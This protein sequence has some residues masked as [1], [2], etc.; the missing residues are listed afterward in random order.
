MTGTPI[1]IDVYRASDFV[2]TNGVARGEPLSFAD[3][4]MLDD[5]YQ[6]APGGR[7]EQLDLAPQTGQTVLSRRD[8]PYSLVHLDCCITLMTPQGATH[9]A[10]ILVEVADDAVVDV[11]LLPLGPLVPQVDYRLVGV[12]RHIATRRFAQAG[13]GSFASGTRITMGDGRLCPVETLAPGDLILTRDSGKQPLRWIGKTTL[14]A[15]GS[16]APVVIAK[17]ALHNAADLVVRADHRLFVYQRADHLGAGRAEVL[18]RARHLINGDTVFLRP[19]GFIDYYQLVFDAHHIIFAE[20]ISA[21]S[22]R[23]DAASRPALPDDAP[24]AD[25]PPARLLGYEVAAN[26]IAPA[27]AAALLHKASAR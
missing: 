20:G 21:E 15:S 6:L 26:L 1:I 14:R 25:H 10:L 19:G 18:I 23:V 9:E 13:C 24:L 7:T 2:A 27:K 17:G 5:V 3:E 8:R 22:Q 11:Y 16:F 12:E 4:L